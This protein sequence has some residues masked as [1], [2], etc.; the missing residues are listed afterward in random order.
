MRA[1]V[2]PPLAVLEPRAKLSYWLS[3]S[4]YMAI[5]AL[6]SGWFLLLAPASA[7]NPWVIWSLH[8]VPLLAFAGVVYKKAPRGHAWLCFVLILY[9]NEAVL[10]AATN[11]A[12]RS[13]GIAYSL[14]VVI[15][16]SS[17]MMYARWGSQLARHPDRQPS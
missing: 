13:F 12:S 8:A 4:S 7:A 17:A 5:L 16:F 11:P 10:M 2:L 9:F 14:A 1:K 6:L 3:A 15:A